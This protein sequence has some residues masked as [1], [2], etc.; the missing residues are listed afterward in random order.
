MERFLINNEI[1]KNATIPYV[2]KG[3]WSIPEILVEILKYTGKASLKIATFSI[4]DSTMRPFFIAKEDGLI[5][6]MHFIVDHRVKQWMLGALLFAQSF[7]SNIRITENHMKIF[8]VYNDNYKIALISSANLNKNYRYEA[9]F[10]TTEKHIFDFYDSQ[11]DEIYNN[12]SRPI[13]I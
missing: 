13:E 12:D 1:P 10:L 9:G 7:T 5:E 6:D 3:D 4:V 11:F 2:N 8:L